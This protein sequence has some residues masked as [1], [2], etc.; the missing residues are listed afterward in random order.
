MIR[1]TFSSSL[2]IL[3]NESRCAITYDIAAGL[4]RH[5]VAGRGGTW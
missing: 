2:D 5:E 1:L 3:S 4:P